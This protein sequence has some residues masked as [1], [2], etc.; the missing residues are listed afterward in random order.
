MNFLNY[1]K[2]SYLGHLTS[3]LDLTGCKD[4]RITQSNDTKESTKQKTKAEKVAIID[5]EKNVAEHG[6]APELQEKKES[7]GEIKVEGNQEK[8]LKNNVQQS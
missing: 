7:A 8:A 4:A 1:G 3:Y 5:L 2:N 6:K